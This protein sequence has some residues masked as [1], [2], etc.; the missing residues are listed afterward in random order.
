MGPH[1]E[2]ADTPSPPLPEEALRWLSLAEDDRVEL[3]E[4]RLVR[5]AMATIEHGAA[6]GAVF[7][8]INRFQGPPGGGRGG[9]WLSQEVR[10]NISGQGLRPDLCG[11]RVD[12]HP[13][14]P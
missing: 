12:R 8:Q 14:P 7:G 4:G 5:K 1:P 6:A 3:L 2:S 10:L 11:W 9:W 13:R